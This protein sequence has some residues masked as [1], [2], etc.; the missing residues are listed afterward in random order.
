[1]KTADKQHIHSTSA[2]TTASN[3]WSNLMQGGALMLPMFFKRLLTPVFWSGQSVLLSCPMNSRLSCSLQH[4]QTTGGRK[5]REMPRN[6]GTFNLIWGGESA[7]VLRLPYALPPV[8]AVKTLL[9]IS[10][11]GDLLWWQH[12]D[13]VRHCIWARLRFYPSPIFLSSNLIWW[14]FSVDPL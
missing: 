6:S 8:L 3:S 7:Y 10:W 11:G 12:R 9:S 14:I 1:M 13:K 2:P 5:M 4:N